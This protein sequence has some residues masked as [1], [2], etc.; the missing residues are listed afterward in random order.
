MGKIVKFN[1]MEFAPIKGY[2]Y[3][4]DYVEAIS[5]LNEKQSISNVEVIEHFVLTDLFF[6]LFFILRIPP[7]N[8]P[9]VMDM[10]KEVETG[11]STDTIDIWGRFHYKSTII[12]IS[13]T[14][15]YHLRHPERCSCIFSYKKAAAEKFLLSIRTA[16]ESD[17]L[18]Y[19]F[20]SIVWEEPA[21]MAPSWSIQNGITLKRKS[22]SRPQRTVQASGLVEG[23]LQGDHFD[24]RIYDD[25]ETDDMK[26]S[27]EQMQKCFDKFIMSQNL[28]TGRDYDSKRIVGTFYSNMGPLVAISRLTTIS[29]DPVYTLRIKP[30]TDNGQVDGNPVLISQ[31]KLDSLKKQST[32]YSQQLCDPTPKTDMQLDPSLLDEM[33]PSDLPKKLY[34]FMIIDPAGSYEGKNN[35]SKRD[36]WAIHVIGLSGTSDDIG[37]NDIYLIDSFIDKIDEAAVVFLLNTMYWRNALIELVAYEKTGGIT[38]GWI[39]HFTNMLKKRGAVLS[40]AMQNLVT[41]HPHNRE[42]KNRITSALRLPLLNNKIHYLNTIDEKYIDRLKNEMQLHPVWHDDGIDALSYIYQVLEE[43][44]FRWKVGIKEEVND[45]GIDYSSGEQGWMSV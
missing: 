9:F 4:N 39:V 8:H 38:P 2:E 19:L 20:P 22:E 37:A 34:K 17:V 21:K 45:Y 6:I 24:R 10:C 12:T 40:E 1:D 35:D 30:A 44:G 11:P 43:Y 14:V 42:K 23:M 25:I 41:V 13:E 3:A 27:Q 7:A 16:Y 31:E 33:S 32:F 28:A 26:Y 18:K 5:K 15:Q 29:G 36:A